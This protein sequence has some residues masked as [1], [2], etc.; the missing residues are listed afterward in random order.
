MSVFEFTQLLHNSARHAA[1]RGTE[2]ATT[3]AIWAVYGNP[4]PFTHGFACSPV[5]GGQT[6]QAVCVCVHVYMNI[7]LYTSMYNETYI[8][9]LVGHRTRN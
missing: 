5:V 7:C 6:A 9:K 2:I 4:K 1:T 3:P 8:L